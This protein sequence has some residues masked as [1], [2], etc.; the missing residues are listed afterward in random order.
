[1][2]RS[3]SDYFSAE[4]ASGHEPQSDINMENLNTQM[5]STTSILEHNFDYQALSGALSAT[6]LQS[7]KKIGQKP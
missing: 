5:D 2:V 6:T 4:E 3:D 1:M 7:L